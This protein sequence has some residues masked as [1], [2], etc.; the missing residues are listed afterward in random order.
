MP[1]AL[2]WSAIWAS[3]SG[4]FALGVSGDPQGIPVL[5]VALHVVPAPPLLIVSAGSDPG[6]TGWAA[7]PIPDQGALTGKTVFG[8]FLWLGWPAEECKPSAFGLST[9]VGVALTFQP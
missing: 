8:Q 9:S 3:T 1:R 4:V 2:A 6:G 7:L 5:G